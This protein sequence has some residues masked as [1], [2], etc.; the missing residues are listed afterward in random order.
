MKFIL[1]HTM[2][3]KHTLALLALALFSYAANAQNIQKDITLRV[4]RDKTTIR[5][6]NLFAGNIIIGV[7][8]KGAVRLNALPGTQYSYLDPFNTHNGK[9]GTI[10]NKQVSYYDNFEE[11]RAGKIKSIGNITITYYDIFDGF[12]NIGLVKNVGGTPITYYSKYDGFDNIGK[13]KSIGGVSIKY[14]DHYDGDD[15]NGKIKSVGNIAIKY[16]DHYE[17]FDKIGQ[18]KSITGQ[19][20]HVTIDGLTDEDLANADTEF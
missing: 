18:I 16:Y 2:K 4:S 10:D 17:T 20:P 14:Y 12:E 1:S 8:Q 15:V 19:T 5:S 7:S 11:S 3:I 6:I 13:I 9:F